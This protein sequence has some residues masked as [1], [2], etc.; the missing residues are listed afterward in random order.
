MNV[1]PQ[2]LAEA[3]GVQFIAPE[4]QVIRMA[5]EDDL[6]FYTL[7]TGRHQL[8][9]ERG[10][11][12]FLLSEDRAQ[13]IVRR[14]PVVLESVWFATVI[15]GY[16]PEDKTCGLKTRAHLPYVNGCATRQLF[17]PE[18]PGDPTLQWLDM[19]PWSAEQ[20]HHIHA[21]VRIVYVFRGRGACV[22][23]MEHQQLRT[24]LYPGQIIVL[25]KMCPHHF[26]TQAERLLVIPLHVF[27]SVGLQEQM[28]PMFQ[29]TH[30]T[31]T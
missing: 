15:R 21:T 31:R 29:G 3:Y 23:G 16:M 19:P 22:V 10:D 18:R 8:V 25:E 7:Y 2:S 27:S 28:H 14:G 11:C 4:E 12:V 30:F 13:V 17:P 6:Y 26:E 9:I 1:D 20:A 24:E 5:R